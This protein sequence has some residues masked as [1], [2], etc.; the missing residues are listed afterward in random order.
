VTAIDATGSNLYERSAGVNDLC[1][2]RRLSRL[3]SNA[4][5]AKLTLRNGAGQ[6]TIETDA[7]LAR[8]HAQ[9][10]LSALR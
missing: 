4:G 1:W 5:N 10:A 6:P 9:P 2:P 7:R 3:R 8:K